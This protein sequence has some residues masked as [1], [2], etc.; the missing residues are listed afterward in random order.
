MRFHATTKRVFVRQSWLNDMLICT[1][2]ARLAKVMPNMRVGS[3]VTLMGTAVHYA[4][5][6]AIN[7][8]MQGHDA[9]AMTQ[10]AVEKFTELQ[11]TERWKETNIDPEKYEVFI[12]SMCKSWHDDIAP[13][14]TF[15]GKVEYQFAYPLGVEVQGWSVWCEGTIDY[16]DPNGVVYDWKTANRP[17]NARDKQSTAVQPTVYAGAVAAMGWSEYP[18]DFRYGVMLRQEKPKSQILKV[19]R[20]ESHLRWLRH[21]VRPLI[22]M[23]IAIGEDKLWVMND[24]G[25]LCSERWCPYWSVCK[26][27]FLSPVDLFVP[28]Q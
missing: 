4:I 17:Y 9:D 23:S 16:V 5:E 28:E 11:A 15:G 2:R 8:E 18:V 19:T 3:D 6:Q 21:A 1:E 10:V 7:T 26:G 27:A 24:T 25:A 14:L 22:E 20:T 13:T 12:Q